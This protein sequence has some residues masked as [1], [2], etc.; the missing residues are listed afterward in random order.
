MNAMKIARL[1]PIPE[2]HEGTDREESL[3]ARWTVDRRKNAVAVRVVPDDEFDAYPEA[4]DN[5]RALHPE[6]E[7]LPISEGSSLYV[8]LHDEVLSA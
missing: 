6:P 8:L 1:Y 7:L 5:K 2:T 3:N 4:K